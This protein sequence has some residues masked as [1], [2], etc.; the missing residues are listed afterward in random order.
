MDSEYPAR[1]LD[2]PVRAA[3]TQRTQRTV[4]GCVWHSLI[5]I[6]VLLLQMSVS[7]ATFSCWLSMVLG[8]AGGGT[9]R[10]VQ[11]L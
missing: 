11:V 9:L 10:E 6:L 5:H 2:Q 7:I 8:G 1:D 4:I 3:D